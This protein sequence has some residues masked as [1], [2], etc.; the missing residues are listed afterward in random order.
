V[1]GAPPSVVAEGSAAPPSFAD[2]EQALY[3]KLDA[4]PS[5]TY[6]ATCCACIMSCET[7]DAP[8]TAKARFTIQVGRDVSE[9]KEV[10]DPLEWTRCNSLYFTETTYAGADCPT[11]KAGGVK[12]PTP[13]SGDPWSGVLFEHYSNSGVDLT[14]LLDIC[15]DP[16]QPQGGRALKYT[17]CQAKSGT[18]ALTEDCGT[19]SA[20]KDPSTS[21]T[22]HSRLT[23]LKILRFQNLSPGTIAM[24]AMVDEI[25][26][27]AVCCDLHEPDCA[28][29]PE[30][31]SLAGG[32]KSAQN[33]LPNL[34][35]PAGCP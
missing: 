24:E 17:L 20:Y 13:N 9:L 10:T 19:A 23:G 15:T 30:T 33:A 14:N 5:V 25:A 27:V 12:G 7:F 3:A 22:F 28:C 29:G 8:N 6:A 1:L 2:L 4:A 32:G 18:A 31:C 34:S 35:C 21:G 26:Q 16:P 11:A